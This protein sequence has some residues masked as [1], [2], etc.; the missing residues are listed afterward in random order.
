M[1]DF[2]INFAPLQGYT[3][4]TYRET[5]NECFGGINEYYSPFLRLQHNNTLRN[6]DI[7]DVA[8]MNNVGI[9]FVPQIIGGNIEE[10]ETLFNY[11]SKHNY[12][13]VDINL[14]C[15]FSMI[16]N[17]GRGSRTLADLEKIKTILSLIKS[18]P[19][20]SVSLKMRLGLNSVEDSLVLLP[21]INKVNLH[22]IVLHARLAKAGYK[23]KVDMEGFTSF[24]N[25]CNHNL[26]YNG[27]LLT[28]KDIDAIRNR[29]PKLSGVM[30]GRGL[31]SDPALALKYRK[32]ESY[33]ETEIKFMEEESYSRFEEELKIKN[34]ND[35]LNN[36]DNK[37][38][39]KEE[40]FKFH[41]LLLERYNSTFEGGEHQILQK[42]KTIWEYF[43]PQTDKKTLKSIKKAKNIRIYLD[44]VNSLFKNSEL[45]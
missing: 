25:I 12:K 32:Y 26:Y 9:N 5:H 36:C 16:M 21:Y 37:S 22:S 15:P 34:I 39:Y 38:I 13:R 40:Y 2:K 43:L 6:K 10:M 29:F 27:D 24:Y 28:V 31:L 1:K 35:Y 3:D 8:Q 11:L 14:G 42:M 19:Q 30:I 18:S 4:Y 44:V 23:G 45:S 20:L 33:V 17:S 41:N 7:R